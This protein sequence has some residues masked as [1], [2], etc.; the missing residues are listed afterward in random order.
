MKGENCMAEKIQKVIDYFEIPVDLAK[1]L[2]EL[3]TKQAITEKLLLQVL[4]DDEKYEHVEAKLTPI[5]EK[6]EA[7]K[8]KVTKEYVPKKY[9][10][11]KYTWNYNGFTVSENKVEIIEEVLS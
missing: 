5:V 4:G 9:N 1:E 10:S 8:I 2:S 3:L 11:I 7:I 6:I